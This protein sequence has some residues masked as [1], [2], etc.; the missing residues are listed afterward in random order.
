VNSIVN[1]LELAFRLFDCKME[2]LVDFKQLD[3][4]IRNLLSNKYDD[5]ANFETILDCVLSHIQKLP[6]KRQAELLKI[7]TNRPGNFLF[8]SQPFYH[9]FLSK[10]IEYE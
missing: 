5:I 4:A 9:R 7:I 8:V 10:L 1:L 2:L 3:D 6:I